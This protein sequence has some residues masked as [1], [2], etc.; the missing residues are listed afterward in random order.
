MEAIDCLAHNILL[1]YPGF[2][3][4]SF[5]EAAWNGLEP[6]DI[7]DRGQHLAKALRQHLPSKY[8]E[9]IDIILSSLTEPLTS[10]AS[11]AL[12]GLELFQANC[13]CS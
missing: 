7:M 8:S 9:A 1:V 10:L 12:L 4:K 3:E 2:D 13:F 5:R 6:L 11:L